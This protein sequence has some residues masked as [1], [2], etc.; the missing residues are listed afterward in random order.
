MEP[1][2]KSR[3][4]R[5]SLKEVRKKL[6]L[7]QDDVAAILDTKRARV[8]NIERGV[9][10]P[11]WLKKAIALNKLLES[12]GYTFNDLLLALPDPDDRPVRL[13]EKRGEYRIGED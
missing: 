13:T 10:I 4:K 2:N 12:A 9:E 6:K 1:S 5:V 3:K 11:D 7:T 8:S